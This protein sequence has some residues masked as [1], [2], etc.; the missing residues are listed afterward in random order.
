MVPFP[1]GCDLSGTFH[2]GYASSVSRH[3]EKS[4]CFIPLRFREGGERGAEGEPGGHARTR[5]QEV[6]SVHH[7]SRISSDT[8]SSLSS[9]AKSSKAGGPKR[10]RAL[11][12]NPK[13]SVGIP[14]RFE[15]SF[16][17]AFWS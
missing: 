5:D 7:W 3:S 16:S 9:T 10:P 17:F 6:A 12:L 4:G 14:T 13:G 8:P 1:T 15:S 11:R 2:G